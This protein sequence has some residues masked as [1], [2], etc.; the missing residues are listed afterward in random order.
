ML[1]P[2]IRADGRQRHILGPVTEGS[3]LRSA[4]PPTSDRGSAPERGAAPRLPFALLPLQRLAGN[5]A[6]IQLLTKDRPASA[7]AL[8][9][10]VAIAEAEIARSSVPGMAAAADHPARPVDANQG[11]P[12]P[13]PTKST[14]ESRLGVELSDVR[15]HRGG[16]HSEVAAALGVRA[17]TVGGDVAFAPGEPEAGAVRP[18]PVLSHELAHVRENVRGQSPGA[19]KAYE[20][21]EHRYL[22]DEGLLAVRD[23]VGTEDGRRWAARLGYDPR[24][25]GAQIDADPMARGGKIRVRDGLELTPGEIVALAG[26]FYGSP[27]A[28][29]GSRRGKR[30]SGD[31]PP[32]PG[33]ADQILGEMRREGTVEAET[34]GPGS[35]TKVYDDISGGRYLE[36][37]QQNVTHFAGANRA[38]W[39]AL[40]TRA[41]SLAREAGAQRAGGGRRNDAD[42]A[43]RQFDLALTTDAF[44]GHFLTDAYA[45]GHLFRKP[46]VEA[47]ILVHIGSNPVRAT[48]H[49]AMQSLVGGLQLARPQLLGQLVLKNI[50]DRL[51]R[52][53][54]PATNAKGM[55]WRT[56]GDDHLRTAV[57]TRHLAALAVFVSRQQVMRARNG[58]NPD[59]SEV[60]DLLPDDDTVERATQAAIGLIPQAA[61]EVDDL[62]I[63][64]R[65]IL[66]GPLPGYIDYMTQQ[67]ANPAIPAM[68]GSDGGD[69]RHGVQ[70]GV[71]ISLQFIRASPLP[72]AAAPSHP[73]APTL[74]RA[75]QP[76]D[77]TAEM[78]GA[79]FTLAADYAAGPVPL[80]VGQA[81]EVAGW[82]NAKS[83]ALVKVV[84]PNPKAPAAFD[85]PKKLLR[86]ASSGV[87][88]IAAY[89]AGLDK[90]AGDVERGE[91]KIDAEKTRKGGARPG[92]VPRLEGLQKNRQQFLNRRLIQASFLNRFD[93][94]MRKWTDFYNTK[95]GFTGKRALDANLVK[96]MLFQETQMGTSGQHLEDLAETDPKVKTRQN[97]LQNVDS[98]AEALF[99][100]IGEEAQPLVAKHGLDAVR[101]DLA[102]VK[103]TEAFLWADPR[104]TAAVAEFFADVPAGSPARNVDY[105]FWIK[106]GIRWLFHKRR[107]VKSWEEAAR[108][109]NGGGAD[110]RRYK[111]EVLDR[112]K[113]ATQAQAAGKEFVPGKL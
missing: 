22:G 77:L 14:Y 25:L 40:H 111:T 15:I 83:V 66:P 47:A 6:V 43:Q 44:G 104:F 107:R 60:T 70:G 27:E 32:A 76:E 48:R 51:N 23:F 28:L 52:D 97:V 84:P 61:T 29:I 16:P 69:W 1:A 38:E 55:T 34:R 99:E 20:S 71:G 58:E 50:H 89:G 41:I 46:D 9:S 21:Y 73:T 106:S 110:A 31:Q 54:F 79:R 56:Y 42:D 95:F 65:S 100:M 68:P 102:K 81:V 36:L 5:K 10:E 33:E 3:R 109:F 78:Q 88:G 108:A 24:V 53:G 86:L 62:M 11:Q 74:Q 87:A 35:R 101:K 105:G 7:Q 90:V 112:M 12:I 17:F 64:N 96:S 63:R 98:S 26:D 45:S 59:A 8:D 93:A 39:L 103:D 91:Q 49:P 2:T 92:E 13:A 113:K 75:I 4:K 19:L 85:V 30:Q 94:D 37:A 18:G 72:N 82:D 80:K 67:P 57:E